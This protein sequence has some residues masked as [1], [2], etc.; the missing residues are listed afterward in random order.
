MFLPVIVN[1]PKASVIFFGE[2]IEVVPATQDPH[3]ATVL[4]EAL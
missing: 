1:H 2:I 4:K 3:R